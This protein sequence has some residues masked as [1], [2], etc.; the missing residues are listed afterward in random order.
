MSEIKAGKKSGTGKEAIGK[1]GEPCS[2]RLI[3]CAKEWRATV[4]Y[5][6]MSIIQVPIPKCL[7]LLGP[8]T[9]AE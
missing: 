1:K 9:I 6:G 2:Q 8:I 5:D 3:L 7:L 4:R